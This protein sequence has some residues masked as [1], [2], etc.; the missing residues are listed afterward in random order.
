MNVGVLAIVTLGATI[1]I[2]LIVRI[3]ND[4][5]RSKVPVHTVASAPAGVVRILGIAQPLPGTPPFLSPFSN[6]PRLGYEA[7]VEYMGGLRSILSSTRWGVAPF[8]LLDDT[9][10]AVVDVSGGSPS[11]SGGRVSLDVGIL[12]LGASI[13]KYP[14]LRMFDRDN[15]DKL[16]ERVLLPNDRVTIYGYATRDPAPSGGDDDRSGGA[17]AGSHHQAAGGRAVDDRDRSEVSQSFSSAR[18]T[19]RTRGGADDVSRRQATNPSRRETV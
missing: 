11:L 1:V 14:A 17:Q 9:G 15:V 8:I 7:V 2:G 6:T 3:K 13:D 16:V 18:P 4:H 5:R 12:D 10:A 19:V